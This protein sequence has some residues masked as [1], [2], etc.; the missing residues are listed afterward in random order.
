MSTFYLLPPRCV[1]AERF[2]ETLRDMVPAADW[3]TDSLADS[4]EGLLLEH[5]DVYVVWREDLP[6]GVDPL[7]VLVEAYGAEE[8]DEVIEVRSNR[9]GVWASLR[10][11]VLAAA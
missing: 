5:P 8:G 3:T 2:A 4:F 11:P 1:V 7:T 9:A 6:V 10:W